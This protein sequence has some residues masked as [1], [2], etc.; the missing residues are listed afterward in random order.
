MPNKRQIAPKG[1]I[2]GWFI[3][4]KTLSGICKAQ[5][6]YKDW[7]GGWWVW[8]TH[9]YVQ[10]VYIAREIM[11]GVAKSGRPGSMYLKIEDEVGANIAMSR[12]PGSGKISRKA[13]VSGKVD[14]TLFKASG[15]PRAFIEVKRKVKTSS[16]LK[17]DIS[18]IK[19]ALRNKDNSFEFCLI[20]FYTSR[21]RTS[22]DS[23]GARVAIEERLE[24]IID[25][26]R[27]FLGKKYDLGSCHKVAGEDDD[28]WA[29]CVLQIRGAPATVR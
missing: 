14:I 6:D 16:E 28:A 19:T 8:Q 18:R 11:K 23:N 4:E 2:P 17:N 25:A 10:T 24:K 15:D 26:V 27:S 12:G 29:A 22:T 7:S 13:R 1:P 9:E 20:A 5:K 21:E 3:I